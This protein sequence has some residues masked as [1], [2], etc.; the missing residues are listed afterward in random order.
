MA[1][2]P[3][4]FHQ[5]NHLHHS[6]AQDQQFKSFFS[7]TQLRAPLIHSCTM[8]QSSCNTSIQF[9][10]DL[11]TLHPWAVLSDVMFTSKKQTS[12]MFYTV[13]ITYA[14]SLGLSLMHQHNLRIILQNTI[15]KHNSGNYRTL[16]SVNLELQDI[17]RHD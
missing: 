4:A 10:S 13:A 12:W 8:K 16:A 7:Q 9:V 2:K 6:A 1:Q 5:Q 17:H 11:Y 3:K 14:T 15:F